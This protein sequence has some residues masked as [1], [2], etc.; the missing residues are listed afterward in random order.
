MGLLWRFS[1]E[2]L[3]RFRGHVVYVLDEVDRKSFSKFPTFTRNSLNDSSASISIVLLDTQEQNHLFLPCRRRDPCSH[4]VKSQRECQCFRVAENLLKY[5]KVD[6]ISLSACTTCC[7]ICQ[8]IGIR[9][10][11]TVFSGKHITCKGD[12]DQSLFSYRWGSSFVI[13]ARRND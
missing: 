6:H 4:V 2:V 13:N 1:L 5:T 10:H 3:S 7:S 9:N 8:T 12:I 11:N